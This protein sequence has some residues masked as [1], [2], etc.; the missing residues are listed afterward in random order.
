MEHSINNTK[1]NRHI[2]RDKS[3]VTINDLELKSI[4]K[5]GIKKMV[6][7]IINNCFNVILGKLLACT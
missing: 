1:T 4:K 7:K 3:N 6:S 2:K 5:Y